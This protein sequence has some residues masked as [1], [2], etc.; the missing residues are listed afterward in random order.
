MALPTVLNFYFSS[1]LPNICPNSSGVFY[2]VD[3]FRMNFTFNWYAQSI[4]PLIS[5]F[6]IIT[7]F[8]VC[9]HST[10]WL[11]RKFQWKG[12]GYRINCQLLFGNKI[13]MHVPISQR[14]SSAPKQAPSSTRHKPSADQSPW[15]Y[16]E[17]FERSLEYYEIIQLINIAF[18]PPTLLST[19]IIFFK[20]FFCFFWKTFR[21][22]F[23][24]MEQSYAILILL[25]P[26]D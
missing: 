7:D 10:V 13:H 3:N 14:L 8:A 21:G 17:A 26:S 25:I 18:F 15:T 6:S 2:V 12:E 9:I 5:W 4:L 19:A 23:C 1:Y 16:R 11:I 20:F 22:R 24:N